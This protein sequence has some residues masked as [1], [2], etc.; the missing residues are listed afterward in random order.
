MPV[1]T[2][3]RL[4]FPNPAQRTSH[5][6]RQKSLCSILSKEIVY[7][8]FQLPRN[9]YGVLCKRRHYPIPKVL[10]ELSQHLHLPPVAAIHIQ[11]VEYTG[12]QNPDKPS[13]ITN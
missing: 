10:K 1:K 12:C 3:P 5:W 6:S 9:G 13:P 7:K 8:D 2:S 4:L 11:H